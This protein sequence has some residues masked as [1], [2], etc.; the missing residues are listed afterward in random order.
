MTAGADGLARGRQQAAAAAAA[1]GS[2]FLGRS[3]AR[4]PEP[5]GRR[6][7]GWSQALPLPAPL[8][9]TQ[10]P[11]L[12]LELQAIEHAPLWHTVACVGSQVRAG[13]PGRA[14]RGRR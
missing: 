2:S 13:P 8:L 7:A 9:C 3:L 1:A 10:V 11:V 14:L 4:R 12:Y 6:L 5:G